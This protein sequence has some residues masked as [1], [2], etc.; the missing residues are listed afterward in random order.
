MSQKTLSNPRLFYQDSEP[1]TQQTEL[2]A[3]DL[4]AAVALNGLIA[5][6]VS[7]TGNAHGTAVA[8]AALAYDYADAILV[9]RERK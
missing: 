1:G 8:R 7:Y 3:R 9:E 6:G 4:F 5:G 2:T